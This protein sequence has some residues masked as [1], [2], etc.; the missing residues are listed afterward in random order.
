MARN[1]TY[2]GISADL[3]TERNISDPTEFS[4]A[5]AFLYLEHRASTWAVVSL[6]P[7]T[8]HGIVRSSTKRP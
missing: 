8:W 7:L 2:Q 5:L 1:D 6:A 4:A 3:M